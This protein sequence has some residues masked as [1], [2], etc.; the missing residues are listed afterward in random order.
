M[1]FISRT[2]PIGMKYTPP[3]P[4]TGSGNEIYQNGYETARKYSFEEHSSE[5]KFQKYNKNE[6][7]VKVQVTEPW[8]GEESINDE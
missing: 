7:I 1:P 2:T 6:S 3:N 8:D 5:N 4:Q